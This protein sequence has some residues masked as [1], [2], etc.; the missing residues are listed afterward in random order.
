MLN[1]CISTSLLSTYP[2]VGKN[3]S[4]YVCCSCGSICVVL[5]GW[6]TAYKSVINVA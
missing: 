5:I 1:N 3:L 4:G 2:A 6:L